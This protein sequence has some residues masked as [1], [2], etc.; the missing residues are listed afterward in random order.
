M[1]DIKP[2][3]QL[4]CSELGPY[5][6]G[7]DSFIDNLGTAGRFEKTSLRSMPVDSYV[8]NMLAVGVLNRIMRTAFLKTERKIIVLPDC[9]KKLQ[10]LGMLQE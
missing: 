9:L 10:R 1:I 6:S 4:G 2:F 5:L 3:L 7:V 8:R